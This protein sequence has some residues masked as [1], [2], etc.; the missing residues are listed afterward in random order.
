MDPALRSGS[1]DS[2]SIFSTPNSSMDLDFDNSACKRLISGTHSQQEVIDLLEKI[3]TSRDEVK[4]IGYLHGDKAQAFIDVLDKALD[5]PNLQPRY[6]N[7]CLSVL[8]KLCGRR[9][10]LPNS[11]QIP[12][13][14]DQSDTPLYRGGFAEVWKGEHQG[15]Q[16]AVKVLRVYSTSDFEKI[17]S[18]FCR[19]VV[20]WKTLHHPN[21]LPLL[22]VT[23]GVY[24]FALASEWMKN[25]NINE[26]ARARPNVNR[27]ELLKDVALG[28]IYMH[29]KVVIHGDLKGAN[30]L[31]DQD[32]HARLADFGLLTIVLDLTNLTV[33][34]SSAEGGM[35]RWTSPELLDPDRFG[36]KDNK[37]TRESDCYALGMVIYEVLSGKFPFAPLKDFIVMWKVIEG[38]R[39]EIPEG[40]ERAWFTGNLWQMLERCWESEPKSRPSIAA[41]QGHLEQASRAWN[42]PAP[43]ADEDVEMDGDDDLTTKPHRPTLN[44][45]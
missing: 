24:D 16:V 23:M 18:R 36:L 7:K 41:V 38:E 8:C 43:P 12:L 26:F 27:F 6:R 4:T 25:G 39:P 15:R 22:G 44:H 28:L 9:A 30:I 34:G 14:Y 21:V 40:V 37:P 5:F 2:E 19:E 29:G 35:I 42:P 1:Q 3:F 13:C 11:L 17:A 45:P 31:I 10:L 32:G 33:S 20:T